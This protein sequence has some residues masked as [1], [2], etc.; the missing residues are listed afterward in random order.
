MCGFSTPPSRRQLLLA[1]AALP[2]LVHVG[3]TSPAAALDGVDVLPRSTWGANLPP[4]GPLSEELGGDVRFL[5]VHHTLTPNTDAEGDV[6]RRLRGIYGYH[7][8][9]KGWPDIAYNFLV[10]RFGRVWEGR[11][12]S[13]NGPVKGDA[14]GG[15]QG[16]ALLC[17][18]IGD[19]TTA[20]PSAAAQ[21]AMG[22]LLG[23]LAARYGIDVSP[24]ATTTFVSRGSNRY[25][26]GATVTA[27]TISGHRDM[28]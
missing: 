20:A 16:F 17:C 25:P 19:H 1:G 3:W 6:V 13:L 12:G 9:T 23:A 5:L 24:D 18:F 8:G 14:T 2:L 7:T 11:A 27:Q 21:A 22:R 28:S 4:T 10:D 26:A 15:S